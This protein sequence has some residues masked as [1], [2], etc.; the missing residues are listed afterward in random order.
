MLAPTDII[1][2]LTCRLMAIYPIRTFG[3]P[4]LR[5][6]AAPVKE[7]DGSLAKLVDDMIETMY[8]APGVGLAAPQIGISRRVIVFDAGFGPREMFNPVLVETEGRMVEAP[9]FEEAYDADEVYEFDEG[10][11]S[12]PGHYWL[13]TRP[14]FA[15]ARGLNLAGEEVEYVGD[16]LLGRILQ[17]ELDHLDGMLLTERLDRRAKKQALRDIRSGIEESE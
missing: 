11:L 12:I 7:I 1:G 2:A 10:C 16:E 3:D 17:H 13:I 5:M 4:V 15:W 9:G 14:S 6:P 8:D